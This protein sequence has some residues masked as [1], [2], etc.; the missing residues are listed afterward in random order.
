[1][2]LAAGCLFSGFTA[3]GISLYYFAP[4]QKLNWFSSSLKERGRKKIRTSFI[5]TKQFY[6]SGG[7]KGSR[8]TISVKMQVIPGKKKKTY[9]EKKIQ[10]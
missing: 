2:L 1:M 7:K 3:L 8:G 10:K 4:Q 9:K 5:K 6:E